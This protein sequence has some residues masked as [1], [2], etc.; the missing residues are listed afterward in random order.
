MKHSFEIDQFLNPFR[1]LITEDIF[2]A[3]VLRRIRGCWT[4]IGCN[5][6][7]GCSDLCFFTDYHPPLLKVYTLEERYAE[8]PLY[9]IIN[10][11][12]QELDEEQFPASKYMNADMSDVNLISFIE[13]LRYES[14]DNV[15]Q[16]LRP[17]Y[18]WI[19]SAEFPKGWDYISENNIPFWENFLDRKHS[20]LRLF[21]ESRIPFFM[22]CLDVFQTALGEADVE[23][24]KY[25]SPT[26][27]KEVCLTKR[28]K[29]YHLFLDGEE[30]TVEV[31]LNNNQRMGFFIDI[32]SVD[33]ESIATFKE[34]LEAFLKVAEENT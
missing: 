18:H 9:V 24:I 22:S 29:K 8:E 10:Y 4:I 12:N 31:W 23:W 21:M 17:I 20:R 6:K 19:E 32:N 1:S 28:D 7:P 25:L 34:K 13:S 26:W 15:E 16:I 14:A 33:E 27:I 2:E 3:L 5:W 11:Q 30:R